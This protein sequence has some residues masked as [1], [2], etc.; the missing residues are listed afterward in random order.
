MKQIVYNP[1]N[2]GALSGKRVSAVNSNP[3]KIWLWHMMHLETHVP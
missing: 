2:E 1:V 3:L